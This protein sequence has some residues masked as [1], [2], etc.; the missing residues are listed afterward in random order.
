MDVRTKHVGEIGVMEAAN[1]LHKETGR[2][3]VT[4]AVPPG[5]GYEVP[6]VVSSPM[7]SFRVYVDSSLE[8]GVCRAETKSVPYVLSAQRVES[9]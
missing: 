9:I 1:A 3:A 6:C 2:H 8:P 4:V 5:F 7:G